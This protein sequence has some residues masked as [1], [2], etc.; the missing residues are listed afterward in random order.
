MFG[1]KLSNDNKTVSARGVYEEY[2][3]ALQ[4]KTYIIPIGSTGYAAQEIWEEVEKDIN[5]FPYLK[6]WAHILK[7]SINPDEIIKAI[8]NILDTLQSN[9]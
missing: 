4:S 1:N 5:Q 9:I 6:K 8:L 7:Q 3:M 2:K